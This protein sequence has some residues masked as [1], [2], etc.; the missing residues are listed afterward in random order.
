MN[1]APPFAVER[2][3]HVDQKIEVW[4]R[5]R[6]FVVNLLSRKIF[7]VNIFSDV[8]GVESRV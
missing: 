6:N 4:K 2:F 8:C 7:F 5:T 1:Q 3:L